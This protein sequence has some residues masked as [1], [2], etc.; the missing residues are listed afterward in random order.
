VKKRTVK[1]VL[2][3]IFLLLFALLLPGIAMG[4]LRIMND[5]ELSSITG[6]GTTNLY[7]EENTVRLFLD[8][9]SESFGE[10]DSLKAGYYEKTL[11]GTTSHGWDMN[12]KDLTLGQSYGSPLVIDGLILRVE[13]D[14]ISSQNKQLKSITMGTNNMVGQIT[15][16]FVSTT[17][18]I[19]P[20]VIAPSA[21]N[22]PIVMNRDETLQGPLTIDGGFFIELNLDSTSSDRGIRTIIGYPESS[23]VKMTFSGT[24]WWNEN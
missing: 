7:I 3:V 17:G 13:F 10:I 21:S 8:V 11:S 23:A 22:D 24:D 1:K 20:N 18:A 16:N 6:Q 19:N 15:G 14:D 12:W 4:E 9:H 2:T 5:R